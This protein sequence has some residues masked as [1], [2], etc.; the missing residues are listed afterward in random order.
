M[1]LTRETSDLASFDPR[2]SAR[3]QS[4][5]VS[6]MENTSCCGQP[7]H[8]WCGQVG[9]ERKEAKR[10]SWQ[11]RAE[12]PALRSITSSFPVGEGATQ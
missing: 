11:G 2:G 4:G 8:A 3:A 5:L 1:P 10:G 9:Q 6:G 7:S 12:Q